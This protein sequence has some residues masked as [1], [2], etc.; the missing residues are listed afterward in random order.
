[1]AFDQLIFR[2][3]A[4]GR[5][6]QRKIREEDVRGVLQS[7]DVIERYPDDVPYPSYLVLGF[8]GKRPIHVVAADDAQS[9]QTIVISVYEPDSARWDA[10]FRQRK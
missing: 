4:I 7:G 3:H 2:F 10:S 8:R 1:M 5:M 6:F 9:R